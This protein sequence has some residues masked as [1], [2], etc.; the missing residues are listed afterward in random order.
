MTQSGQTDR[1]FVGRQ[2][3][4]TGLR[5]AMDEA[6]A[7]HGRIVMLAGE[8]GIGK[9]RTARELAA[10]AKQQGARVLW[11]WCYEGEGA[12]SYC[13]WLQTIRA[14]IKQTEAEQLGHFPLAAHKGAGSRLPWLDMLLGHAASI[15]PML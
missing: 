8:P 15:I 2:R 14:Y 5:A 11:G 9:T 12:P 3:E 7:G 4:M 10:L 6:V 1:V 13:P